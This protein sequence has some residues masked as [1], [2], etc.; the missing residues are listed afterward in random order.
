ML[1]RKAV[2]CWWETPRRSAAGP[3]LF[4]MSRGIIT[5]VPADLGV[6]QGR[7]GWNSSSEGWDNWEEEDGGEERLAVGVEVGLGVGAEDFFFLASFFRTV[8]RVAR[9]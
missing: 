1:A 7:L 9:A 6:E 2:A 5:G 3:T 8:S 4:R